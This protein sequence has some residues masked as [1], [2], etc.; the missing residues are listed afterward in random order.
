MRSIFRFLIAVMIP[1]AACT[2]FTASGS[3]E[4]EE[5]AVDASVISVEAR[6][7]L[8][9]GNAGITGLLTAIAMVRSRHDGR[10]TVSPCTAEIDARLPS[11]RTWTTITAPRRVVCTGPV[12]ELSSGESA[13]IAANGDVALFRAV[14]GSDART[15]II[16]IRLQAGAA[17][18]L[19]DIQSDDFVVNRP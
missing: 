10:L 5:I 12:R 7:T 18:Q 17:T 15:V 2:P 19:Y 16:R 9:E 3:E 1:V 4:R 11:S 13:E 14:A 6:S 8:F